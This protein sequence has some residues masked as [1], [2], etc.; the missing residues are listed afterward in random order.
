MV[1]KLFL[2]QTD[3]IAGITVVL[4]H[5]RLSEPIAWHEAL[6]LRLERWVTGHSTDCSRRGPGLVPALTLHFTST[7][8]SSSSFRNPGFCTHINSCTHTEIII[9]KWIF[10]FF[11]KKY[12]CCQKDPLLLVALN[13]CLVSLVQ[14]NRWVRNRLVTFSWVLVRWGIISFLWRIHL[15]NRP[16]KNFISTCDLKL[17]SAPVTATMPPTDSA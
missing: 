3:D 5:R 2:W 7:C 14:E 17:C 9:N 11:L 4:G 15:W 13:Y 16:S 1:Q 10:V 12:S 6:A 8:S